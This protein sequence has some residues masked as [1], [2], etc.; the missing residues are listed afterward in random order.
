MLTNVEKSRKRG[1]DRLEAETPLEA[2][3][4]APLVW[5][6]LESGIL[7]VEAPVK[8]EGKDGTSST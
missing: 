7:G 4:S 3:A 2:L 1:R 5:R 8:V 6:I